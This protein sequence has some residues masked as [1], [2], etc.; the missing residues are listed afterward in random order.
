MQTRFTSL[1]ALALLVSTSAFAQVRG[2]YNYR[3]SNGYE[4]ATPRP[5]VVT[6]PTASSLAHMRGVDNNQY[7]IKGLFNVEADSYLAIFTLTQ[8]AM[9]QQEADSLIRHKTDGIKAA[10]TASGQEVEVFVDMI[11]FVPIYEVQV[12]KKLFSEDTYNEIPKG[13]E[14]K[15]NLHFRYKDASLLEQIVTACARHEVYDLVRVDYA[16]ENLEEKKAELMAKAEEILRQRVSRHER[17]TGKD[18][19]QLQ[20][21]VAEGFRTTYP[22]ERYQTYTAF[23]SNSL[24]VRAENGTIVQQDKT[25]SEF[26]MPIVPKGYDFVVNAGVLEPVVQIEYELMV[27]YLPQEREEVEPQVIT[28]TKVENRIFMVTPDAQVQRLDIR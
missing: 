26:Y 5:S 7:S 11:S 2:N 16:I 21:S 6:L 1:I 25:T 3:Q 9:T 15:K 4:G 19:S 10:I 24:N 13:F 14:I 17:I 8:M 20:I 27:M 23:C 18:F 28:E 12:T 22:I